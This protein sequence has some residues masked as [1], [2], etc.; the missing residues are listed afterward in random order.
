MLYTFTVDHVE[1]SIVSV[2]PIDA[3]RAGAII[4]SYSL[5]K[6]L[7][8]MG[9]HALS[10]FDTKMVEQIVKESGRAERGSCLSSA[11][12]KIP[13]KSFRLYIFMR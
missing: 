4:C 7:K 12:A 9:N 3:P 1:K 13:A 2:L 6:T 11:Y 5:P 8:K 10:Q